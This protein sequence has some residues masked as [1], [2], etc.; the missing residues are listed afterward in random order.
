MEQQTKLQNLADK[1]NLPIREH[2]RLFYGKYLY[3]LECELYR[4]SIP[5]LYEVKTID[6][7]GYKVDTS[8]HVNFVSTMRRFAKKHGDRV[9]V[10]YLN[11]LNYYTDNLDTLK[12]VM[13]YITRLQ[14]TAEDNDRSRSLDMNHIS[15]FPGEITQRYVHFRKKHLPHRRYKYQIFANRMEHDAVLDWEKWSESYG[16]RIRISNYSRYDN[17]WG[18]W[19]THGLWSGESLGYVQDEK[20]LQLV[21][22]KL[23]SNINKIIEYQIRENN[24][25]QP[26]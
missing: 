23:G 7:Y 21:Q 24:E 13:E 20:M 10:E 19:R 17:H 11:T 15:V 4:Y 26:S 2:D 1:F 12:R 25:Q 8:N 14:R 18:Y 9:R 22:F 5:E 6:L 3:R 16:D